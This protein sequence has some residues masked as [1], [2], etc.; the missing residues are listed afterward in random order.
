MKIP[1]KLLKLTI[2]ICCSIFLFCACFNLVQA[3]DPVWARTYGGSGLDNANLAIETT[4][5]GY[6][7][8]GQSRSSDGDL[9]YNIG[10]W[11]FWVIKT[12]LNGRFLSFS[13]L[14][15]TTFADLTA[16]NMCRKRPTS[17]QQRLLLSK[18]WCVRVLC[19]F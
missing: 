8:A 9:A 12:D 4:D 13:F 11:D 1:R 7:I 16:E 10:L 5:G 6:L 2:G 18:S 15:D 19:S 3:Q 14:S 17:F